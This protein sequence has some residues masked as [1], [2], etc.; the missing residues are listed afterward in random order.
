MLNISVFSTGFNAYICY[1]HVQTAYR[2]PIIRV[3]CQMLINETGIHSNRAYKML[4]AKAKIYINRGL[5]NDVCNM[6][7]DRVLI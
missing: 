5:K 1:L 2:N 6:T 3:F 4:N 7:F